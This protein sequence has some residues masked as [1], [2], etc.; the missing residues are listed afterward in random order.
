MI[1]EGKKRYE[2]P[3]MT[4][5]NLEIAQ[6]IATSGDVTVGG[7]GDGGSLGGGEAEEMR[8]AVVNGVTYGI[9][10]YRRIYV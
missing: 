5:I 6:M 10:N 8:L 2:H 1:A 7:W 9:T 3:S 4:I